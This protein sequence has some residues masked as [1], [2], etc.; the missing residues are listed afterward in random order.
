MARWE[1]EDLSGLNIPEPPKTTEVFFGNGGK[2]AEQKMAFAKLITKGD[3]ETY[4]VKY[5]RGDLL[6]PYHAD[7]LTYNRPY[8]DFKKVKKNVFDL[9][10]EYLKSS[11][12]IF[13]TRARRLMM[14]N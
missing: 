14:E 11:S 12:R 9:Y 7:R 2:T 6:D 3:A 1:N 10:I 5:G 13:L 4:Y 8:F